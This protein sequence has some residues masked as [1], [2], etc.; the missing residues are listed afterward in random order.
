MKI[1]RVYLNGLE[2]QEVGNLVAL[3][4]EQ[5]AHLGRSLRMAV[6]DCF[7][8][9]DGQRFSYQATI[10]H[11]V[12]QGQLIGR[13]QQVQPLNNQ[14]LTTVLAVGVCKQDRFEWMVE[15]A[16]ELGATKVVPLKTRHSQPNLKLDRCRKIAIQSSALSNRPIYLQ[17]EEIH[18]LEKFLQQPGFETRTLFSEG[19]SDWQP[20][21]QKNQALVIGPE[22]GF[23]QS[24]IDQA[25]ELGWTVAGLGPLNL[26]VETA[27]IVAI[28][29]ITI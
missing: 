25:Q 11:F 4:L 7:W 13:I 20:Q 6:G 29:R 14:S 28:A 12:K 5:S 10:D 8:V 18:T 2:A 24:E 27:A 1:P 22:G 23:A 19:A 9:G 15:K 21:L 26:R 3:D 17:I 16:A